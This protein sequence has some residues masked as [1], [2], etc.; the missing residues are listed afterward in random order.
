MFSSR[1]V[2]FGRSG[3]GALKWFYGKPQAT[4]TLAHSQGYKT[5][6]TSLIGG[7]QIFEN[8]DRLFS[9]AK[10]S[11]LVD[12]Y[13]IQ[14][15]RTHPHR[16]APPGTPGADKQQKIVDHLIA[17]TKRGVKVSVI[18]DNSY[19]SGAKEYH[20]QR[21][22]E[23]L[24]DNGVEVLAYPRS[25]ARINHIKLLIVDNRY[26]VMGGMNWGNHSPANHDACV[27]LEGDDVGN[28]AEQI[29]KMDYQFSGGDA[30]ALPPFKT[31]PEE[32][33]KVLTTSSCASPDGGKTEILNRIRERIRQAEK[34][35]VCELFTITDKALAEDLVEAHRRLKQKNEAGVKIL[36]DP[37]LYL[38]FKNCR[39]AID[40][41]KQN[42]VPIRFYRVDWSREEKLHAKWA[43]FDEKE[44]LLGSANWSKVGLRSNC[45]TQPGYTSQLQ[46]IKG[47]HEANL[48]ISSPQLCK[49]F[50]KQFFY[51]WFKK[52]MPI[53]GPQAIYRSIPPAIREKMLDFANSAVY[54]APQINPFAPTQSHA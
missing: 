34:S 15:P 19:D 35:I 3:E 48:A 42:G 28:L 1:P 29:F 22:I 18:L 26:A 20:N 41:L 21:I 39:P 44:L 2:L 33:I 8:I 6:V 36:V 30:K 53:R 49:A 47:N 5:T 38:R 7:G 32:K 13:E 24:R 45:P 37:G 25:G 43:V 31:I 12:M 14:D 54:P 27:L 17:L 50:V 51:D 16:S 11:V 46:F 10:R 23:Y 9:K 52:S 40:Y 4:D